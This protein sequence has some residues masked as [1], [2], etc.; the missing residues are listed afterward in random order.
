MENH[1]P[2]R[3]WLL[4]VLLAMVL[5][6][7]T[8]GD[9]PAAPTQPTTTSVATRSSEL[10]AAADDAAFTIDNPVQIDVLANDSGT[11]LQPDPNG[12]QDVFLEVSPPDQGEAEAAP[13]PQSD[14]PRWVVTFIPPPD[15]AWQESTFEYTV[16]AP[17]RSGQDSETRSTA[18][19][20]VRRPEGELA[21]FDDRVSL[22]VTRESSRSFDVL[23]NDVGAD[24]NNARLVRESLEVFTD[25]GTPVARVDLFDRVANFEFTPQPGYQ[26]P[27][28]V[29]FTYSIEN[30]LGARSEATV[31]VTLEGLPQAVDDV[32][33]VNEGFE[34]DIDVLVNDRYPDNDPRRLEIT[35]VSEATW[36]RAELAGDRIIYRTDTNAPLPDGPITFTYTVSTGDQQ[37]GPAFTSTATATVF[38]NRAP[39]AGDDAVTVNEGQTDA[40]TIDVLA[41]DSDPDG[42]A[43]EI[44]DVQSVPGV[45]LSN[46]RILFEPQPNVSNIEFEYGVADDGVPGGSR[47]VD[48]GRV[49]IEVNGVEPIPW[50]FQVEAG[51]TTVLD[52]LQGALDPEGDS[53]SVTAVDHPNATIT[54]DGVTFA[55]PTDACSLS[56]RY[57]VTDSRGAFDSSEIVLD[58]IGGQVPPSFAVPTLTVSDNAEAGTVIGDIIS[59]GG[60]GGR[61]D[62][63]YRI[64]GGNDDGAFAFDELSARL[65]VAD[66][67]LL[68]A[69]TA[70]SRTLTIEFSDAV[71][72]ISRDITVTIN[73]GSAPVVNG[74]RLDNV[75]WIQPE[76]SQY[77]CL[78]ASEPGSIDNRSGFATATSAG[79]LSVVDPDGDSLTFSLST[80]DASF[81]RLAVANAAEAGLISAPPDSELQTSPIEIDPDTGEIRRNGSGELLFWADRT[82]APFTHTVTVSDGVFTVEGRIAV[83]VAESCS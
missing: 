71:F 36:G 73:D 45:S 17:P 67:A 60:C 32:I 70:P 29:S 33:A 21:A 11:L 6:A 19:V 47:L 48:R 79:A 26:P 54:P 58:I 68:D 5:A 57:T 46:G 65:T 42:D 15:E 37:F 66:P 7:C 24:R 62:R 27:A 64:T 9:E 78:Q 61:G 4:V 2:G 1:T 83:I 50:F 53:V 72:T 13:D 3:W 75:F 23:V 22:P 81:V 20:T 12:F 18:T 56:F 8:G 44:I 41:N 43:L 40:I 51:S 52:L 31:T 25:D 30:D 16:V 34:A 63:T 69:D 74:V 59:S 39:V 80:L 38:V 77:F 14:S 55:V 82:R 28:S 10:L 49:R 76:G 35:E